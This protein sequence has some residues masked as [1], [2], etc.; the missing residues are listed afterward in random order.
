MGLSYE[1]KAHKI[2][3][4]NWWAGPMATNMMRGQKGGRI[5]DTTT[6]V[7]GMLRDVGRESESFGC[8]KHARNQSMFNNMPSSWMQKMMFSAGK[9]AH[10]RQ[11]EEKA[12]SL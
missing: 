6:A 3:C 4:L 12:K 10:K 2:D 8:T 11:Q 7:H 9:G 5:V 1:L